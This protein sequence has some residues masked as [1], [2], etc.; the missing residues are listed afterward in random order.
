MDGEKKQ[1]SKPG[2]YLHHGGQIPLSLN[3]V[4]IVNS[5]QNKL[6]I[7]RTKAIVERMSRPTISSHK[8]L[9]I[10][11]PGVNYVDEQK[12]SWKNMTLYKDYHTHMWNDLGTVRTSLRK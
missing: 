11:Y 7:D 8:K 1:P 4:A 5:S 3:H 6:P 2:Q 9:G 12:F 10:W